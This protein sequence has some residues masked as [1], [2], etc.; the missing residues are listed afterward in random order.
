MLFAVGYKQ[1]NRESLRQ[2]G[3]QWQCLNRFKSWPTDDTSGNS[4]NSN[5]VLSSN[6]APESEYNLMSQCQSCECGLVWNW[7]I[8]CRTEYKP[9]SVGRLGVES[10]ILMLTLLLINLYIWIYINFDVN[11]YVRQGWCCWGGLTPPAQRWQAPRAGRTRPN[12]SRYQFAL[13]ETDRGRMACN[14]N[15]I[16]DIWIM[17]GQSIPH[18]CYFLYTARFCTQKRVNQDK[19]N[20][21]TK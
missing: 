21:A 3:G 9:S 12:P 13:R 16:R 2:Q 14:K 10:N 17:K 5:E 18:I 1:I 8:C 7:I 15:H 6:N 20:F 11:K 19:S 4:H